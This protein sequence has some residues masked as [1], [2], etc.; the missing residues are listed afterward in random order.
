M[1]RHNIKRTFFSKELIVTI[2][3][4]IAISMYIWWEKQEQNCTTIFYIMCTSYIDIKSMLIFSFMALPAT[5][6]FAEDIEY[7][8]IHYQLIRGNVKKYVFSK[9]LNIF[10]SSIVT[11]VVCFFSYISI[12]RLLGHRWVDEYYTPIGNGGINTWKYIEDGDFWIFY[13]I[14]SIQ[15]GI[16]SGILNLVAA[17]L[18]LYIKNKMMILATP[19]IVAYILKYYIPGWLLGHRDLNIMAMFNATLNLDLYGNDLF[20]RC[21]WF[22]IIGV[23]GL[24]FIIYKTVRRRLNYD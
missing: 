3:M 5:S 4:F 15:F 7:N 1:I 21:V 2:C 23:I 9:T 6:C 11:M 24:S 8:N 18:S 10:I 19:A 12:L 16:L 14:M 22:G 20:V 17:W 13:I